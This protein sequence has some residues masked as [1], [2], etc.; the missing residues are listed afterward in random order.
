M[1]ISI[2]TI[3]K[4]MKNRLQKNTPVK[5]LVYL[6]IQQEMDI[7]L[8]E[9]I[10]KIISKFNLSEDKKLTEKHFNLGIYPTMMEQYNRLDS[11]GLSNTIGEEE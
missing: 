2:R 10:I 5:E 9:M 6:E 11:Y 1:V 7:M 3:K 4:R 8:E